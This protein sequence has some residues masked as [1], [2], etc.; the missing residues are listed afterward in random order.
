MPTRDPADLWHELV[1]KAGEEETDGAA[2]LSVAQAEG[3]L[4]AAAF[5][6][7][8][9]RAK[10]K[11]FIDALI[12]GT[13]T[14]NGDAQPPTEPTAWVTGPPSARGGSRSV[15]WS[16]LVA[17]AIAAIA[18]AGGVLYAL[19]HRS[20]PRD[21]DVEMP[22]EVVTGEPPASAPSGVTSAAPVGPG[23]PL[24]PVLEPKPPVPRPPG[25]PP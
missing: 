14:A 5:D 18:T 17:A 25:G 20:K 11:A 1:A 19:G 8:S 15:R 21:K 3:E 10:G 9:E 2:S 23:K 16:V 4:Q 13:A 22:R 12:A 6:V 24:A 7:A